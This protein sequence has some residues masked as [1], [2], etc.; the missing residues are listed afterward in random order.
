M[1]RF[2]SGRDALEFLASRIIAEAQREGVALSEVERKMLYFSET[3]PTIPDIMEVNDAFDREYNQD[4]YERKIARLVG[5]ARNRARREGADD[6]KV[7][8]DAERALSR[9]DYYLQV[10]LNQAGSITRLIW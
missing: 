2:A 4:D 8:S 7:W 6:L 1:N 5:N 9:Y 10:I 3:A